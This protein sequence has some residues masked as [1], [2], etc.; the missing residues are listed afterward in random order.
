M[1]IL[2]INQNIEFKAVQN[3]DLCEPN[4]VSCSNTQS[5]FGS[6]QNFTECFDCSETAIVD[7]QQEK[8]QPT[9]RI[10]LGDASDE[11]LSPCNC[12][13]TTKYVHERC[14]VQ[15]FLKS[16]RQMCE[17]CQGEINIKK[18][19]YKPLLKWKLPL[20]LKL[21]TVHLLIALYMIIMVCF[22]SLVIWI[23]IGRCFSIVCTFVY[24]AFCVGAICLV[25]LCKN[26]FSLLNYIKSILYINS[27]WKVYGRKD[28]KNREVS[29]EPED[30]SSI[31][32][33]A[34]V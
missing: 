19:G 30:I 6:V 28:L 1:E 4:L 25:Y 11:L 5:D 22:T 13:G 15:W 26:V 16:K 32:K 23:S 20:S 21:K 2:S 7:I 14:W 27:E 3:D 29:S 34:K 18:T 8:L 9:C 12:T 10:C 33:A 24:A 31:S 17:I